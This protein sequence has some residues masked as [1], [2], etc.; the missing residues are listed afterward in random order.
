MK[1]ALIIAALLC[2]PQIA[3]ALSCR[4]HSVEAAF[5]QADEADA[6]FVIVQG[7]LDFDAG[8]LPKRSNTQAP[9]DRV[10][11][12]RLTGHALS[13]AGFKTPYNKAVDVYVAC[14][15]PWCA[16]VQ[17][18]GK[19]LAFVESGP[20]GR[21]IATNPCGGYLFGN[22]TPRM[23]TAVQQCMAGQRCEALR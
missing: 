22:P 21:V 2:V 15:G 20:Q 14:Y 19:V 5:A 16:N 6:R 9:Q 1:V 13:R 11:K 10:I 8:Q 3:T 17:R 4:P 12:A 7:R 18:G 23:L